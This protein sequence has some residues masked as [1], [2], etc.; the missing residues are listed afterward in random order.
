METFFLG[1]DTKYWVELQKIAKELD[2][3]E[4]NW[5]DETSKLRGKISFYE[6]RIKQMNELR[7]K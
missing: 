3:I 1:H 7:T 5:L 4:L 2:V 6:S